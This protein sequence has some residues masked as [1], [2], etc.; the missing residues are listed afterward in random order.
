MS[1]LGMLTPMAKRVG[2]ALKRAQQALR[3]RMDDVLRPLALTTPQYAV[4][5]ALEREPGISN[6]ALA[7]AAFVTAQTM[8]GIVANLEREGLLRRSADST[9]RRVLQGELTASGRTVLRRA[10]R[11]VAEVEAAMTASLPERDAL[12]LATL[13]TRCADNL[14]PTAKH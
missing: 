1:T 12:K 11:V 8:Q 7:R 9:N 5:S 14:L 13:L 2:Y 6:A 10:H 4:L 3:A